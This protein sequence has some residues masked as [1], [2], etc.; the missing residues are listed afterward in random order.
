MSKPAW[1]SGR[2]ATARL[3]R[4]AIP[5][6]RSTTALAVGLMAGIVVMPIAFGNLLPA[7]ALVLIGLRRRVDPGLGMRLNGTDR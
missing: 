5:G 2:L 7:L 6:R 1:V 3:S 4:L